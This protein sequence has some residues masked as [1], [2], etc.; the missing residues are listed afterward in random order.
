MKTYHP[1]ILEL[2]TLSLLNK[3]IRQSRIFGLFRKNVLITI[4]VYC[5]LQQYRDVSGRNIA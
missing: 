1:E 4:V 5:V 3:V 2:G